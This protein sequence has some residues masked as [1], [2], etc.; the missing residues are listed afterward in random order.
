MGTPKLLSPRG[1][2]PPCR[3]ATQRRV[4]CRYHTMTSPMK[5]TMSPLVLNLS[6]SFRAPKG[7]TLIRANNSAQWSHERKYN[8]V[9]DGG[10]P[11]DRIT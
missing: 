9:I 11:R 7:Q 4:T 6:V 1:T 8:K 5:K 3:H 10:E 2:P